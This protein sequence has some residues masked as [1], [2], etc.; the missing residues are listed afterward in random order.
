MRSTRPT[1]S[2]IVRKPELRHQLAHF[3]GDEAEEVLDVLRLAREL[4]AQLR[5]LR[6]DADRTGVEMADA[7]HHAAQHDQRRRRESEL[8]GAEQRAR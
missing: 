5:I 3:L 8:L 1:I 4:L 7:H 6:R 2:S